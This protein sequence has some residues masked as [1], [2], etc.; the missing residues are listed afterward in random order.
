MR[1]KVKVSIDITVDHIDSVSALL[2]ELA[3]IYARENDKGMLEKQDGD[4]IKWST[5]T[6]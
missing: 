3:P 6:N 2:S 1:N 4:L 5:S